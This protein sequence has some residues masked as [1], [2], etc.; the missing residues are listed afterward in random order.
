MIIRFSNG[1][2]LGPPYDAKAL[3]TPDTIFG[4]NLDDR[5]KC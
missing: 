2:F 3:D 5:E 1:Y 4:Y